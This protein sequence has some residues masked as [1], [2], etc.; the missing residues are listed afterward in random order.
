MDRSL[1]AC[2]RATLESEWPT[3]NDEP[4]PS[5][6]LATMFGSPAPDVMI[7]RDPRAGEP[8]A[9]V[10]FIATPDEASCEDLSARIYELSGGFARLRHT[11]RS[12]DGLSY[13][14][15]PPMFHLVPV[16]AFMAAMDA[17]LA[18]ESVERPIAWIVEPCVLEIS[19][20]GRRWIQRRDDDGVGIEV[21]E[22]D[23]RAGLEVW[24]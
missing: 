16:E 6:H 19:K 24:R 9:P 2:L 4:H 14:F 5:W 1:L 8:L 22:I 10:Y 12:T 21:L 15:V 18:A 13:L 17:A 3:T 23:A 20:A 7:S 11:S